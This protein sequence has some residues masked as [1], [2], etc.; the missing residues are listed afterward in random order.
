[1]PADPGVTTVS[2]SKTV[3]FCCGGCI[4]KWNKLTGD[5]KSMKLAAAK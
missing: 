4:A 1:M 5:E 3:A 2:D